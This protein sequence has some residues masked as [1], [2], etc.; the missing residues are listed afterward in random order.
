MDNATGAAV[1]GQAAPAGLVVFG[2]DDNGKPHASRFG[3][4]EAAL[5]EKAAGL[6]GMSALRIVSAEDHA[7]A[8]ELPGGRVFASGRAF[9]PFVKPKLFSKLEGAGAAFRPEPPAAGPPQPAGRAKGGRRAAAAPH[10]PGGPRS[11]PDGPGTPATDWAGIKV[12]SLALAA[13]EGLPAV[14]YAVTV[15]AERGPD[16]FE[17]R[18]VDDGGE[19][20]PPVIRRREHLGLFPPAVIGL[21]G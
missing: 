16:L 10:A 7:L 3:P 19:D 20:L 12:G 6:M 18:W 14:W 4:S 17:L 1:A 2:R 21:L 11:A 15:L 5:A 8:A 9:V 13:E